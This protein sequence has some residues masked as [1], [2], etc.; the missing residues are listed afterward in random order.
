M[1]LPDPLRNTS[2]FHDKEIAIKKTCILVWSYSVVFQCNFCVFFMCY[3]LYK[4][5]SVKE[6][7]K[8]RDRCELRRELLCSAKSP[9]VKNNK[10]WHKCELQKSAVLAFVMTYPWCGLGVVVFSCLG[11]SVNSLNKQINK[12][13]VFN[14]RMPP[15]YYSMSSDGSE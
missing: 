8:R 5:A 2:V 4:S 14:R 11:L 13:A 1:S 12:L 7:V 10:G 3:S 9:R 6:V 15:L